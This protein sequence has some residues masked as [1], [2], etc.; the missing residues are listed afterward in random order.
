MT[1]TRYFDGGNSVNWD[2]AKDMVL[3]SG[4][5]VRRASWP[6]WVKI[7]PR[8]MPGGVGVEM[9]RTKL[10]GGAVN[11]FPTQEDRKA[12]DWVVVR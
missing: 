10:L 5:G 11:Y 8:T 9:W 12:Q 3:S 6:S 7:V 1:P 2:E 4:L